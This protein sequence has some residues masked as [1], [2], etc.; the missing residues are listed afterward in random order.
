MKTMCWKILLP[1]SISR[2]TNCEMDTGTGYLQASFD[3]L[4]FKAQC[5]GVHSRQALGSLGG[6]WEEELSCQGEKRN[7]CNVLER[8][9]SLFL[10]RSLGTIKEETVLWIINSDFTSDSGSGQEQDLEEHDL[11]LSLQTP[12]KEEVLDE[13]DNINGGEL[14][15]RVLIP[16]NWWSGHNHCQG[17]KACNEV[18]QAFVSVC[19]ARAHGWRGLWRSCP[20]ACRLCYYKLAAGYGNLWDQS[21]QAE[22]LRTQEMHRADSGCIK[23]PRCRSLLSKTRRFFFGLALMSGFVLGELP[24]WKTGKLS[25]L[26]SVW[27]SWYGREMH[28]E[29]GGKATRN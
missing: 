12:L 7:W 22:K 26:P 25:T 23:S 19:K 14:D 16:G 20:A 27:R 18:F 11:F 29:E 10:P 4:G 2:L 21:R 28:K 8:F 24:S 3:V 6:L 15:P 17:W 9:H 5:M 13:A 1:E